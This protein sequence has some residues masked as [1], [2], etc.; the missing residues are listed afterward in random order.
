MTFRCAAAS[1]ERTESMAGTAS[2]VRAFLLVE[3]P[4][5]WGVDALTDARMPDGIGPELR[6]RTKALRIKAAL[7]RRPGGA[8]RRTEGVRVFAAYADPTAPRLETTVLDDLAQVH[9]L[10]LD[11]LAAGRELGLERHDEPV[12]AVCTHGRHDTCCAERGRPVAAGLAEAFPDETWESSHVGGDR[13]AANVVVL[14]H[15]LYYGRLQPDTARGM[16]RLLRAGEVD[17][18][19]LRGRS[20]YA[21]AVQAAEIALRRW[22]D[23]RRLDGVRFV[24]RD[25]DEARTDAVFAIEDRQYAVTV[26]STRSEALQQL[27]CRAL[28][29]NPVMHHEVTEIRAL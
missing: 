5:P 10:D 1:E 14:P 11:A 17:L 26:V 9:D 6:A 19:H 7:I 21:T 13:F 3:H 16:A 24:S 29:E 23:E 22:T 2:Q 27:T 4:G 18:D 12:I 20:A 28:R 15:G 25:V 8:S